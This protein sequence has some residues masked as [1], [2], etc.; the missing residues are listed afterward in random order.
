MNNKLDHH[1]HAAPTAAQ[2][3]AQA[4]AD[5]ATISPAN[6][7]ADERSDLPI[8]GMTC[9]SCANTVENAL[10][11]APG[12]NKATV[13]FLTKTATVQYNAAKT[14]PSTL[15]AAVRETGYGATAP[16]L[17]VPQHNHRENHDAHN[18]KEGV[19]HMQD[20]TIGEHAAHM[21]VNKD[22]QKILLRKVIIGAALSL[23][24]LIIA[25]SH[26]KVAL[27]NQPWINWLQFALTTPVVL[28]SGAQFYRMA[29][30]GLKH[31]RA[32]MDSLVALV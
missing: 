26:G 4:T 30:M 31:F 12:V 27:I 17:K 13:N 22:E 8:S 6:T 11:K 7:A 5:L 1:D 2:P 10:R 3:V 29:W 14:N 20:M 24:V 9:A 25:M 32:N 28:W 23:P 15:A 19:A 18:P 21:H 16:E